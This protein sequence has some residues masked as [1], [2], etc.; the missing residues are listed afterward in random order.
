MDKQRF[1]AL[2]EVVADLVSEKSKDYQG[3][4]FKTQDYF[5]FGDKSYA[6]M[7]YTK[8]MRI[9]SLADRPDDAPTFEGLKDSAQDIVAYAVFYL[10]YLNNHRAPDNSSS[11]L[12]KFVPG[13]SLKKPAK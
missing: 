5:P 2:C 10:D 13:A 6:Q 9:V 4:L 7:L 11:D 1:M 12:F 8:A 3:L